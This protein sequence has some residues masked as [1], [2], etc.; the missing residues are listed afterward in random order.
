MEKPIT[1]S[2]STRQ[3]LTSHRKNLVWSET[4]GSSCAPKCVH[5]RRIRLQTY[6][7]SFESSRWIQSANSRPLLICSFSNNLSSLPT[8]RWHQPCWV[9][10]VRVL[11]RQRHDPSPHRPNSPAR[12]EN[13]LGQNVSIRMD[14]DIP[15]QERC[16]VICVPRQKQRPPECSAPNLLEWRKKSLLHEQERFRLRKRDPAL[17]WS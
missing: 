10:S 16:E 17:W 7:P 12:Q 14:F 4:S 2:I 8:P 9:R 1:N 15:Q 3:K 13:T 6:Q 5:V 11:P